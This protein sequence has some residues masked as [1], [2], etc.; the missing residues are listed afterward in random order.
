MGQSIL[1][2]VLVFFFNKMIHCL[3]KQRMVLPC[4]MASVVLAWLESLQKLENALRGQS[5]GM[6]FV[7]KTCYA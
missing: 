2:V 3:S 1:Y 7:N 6:V 5:T 4:S